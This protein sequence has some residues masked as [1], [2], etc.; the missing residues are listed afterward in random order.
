MD[1]SDPVGQAVPPQPPQGNYR[2]R[3]HYYKAFKQFCAFLSDNHHLQKLE[4]I[5]GKHLTSYVLWMQESSKSASTI[6]TDLAAVQFF[7][8]RMSQPKYQLLSNEEL[9]VE[10]ERR[11]FG[12]VNHTWSNVESSKMLGK[13]MAEDRYDSV[14]AFYLVRYAG[15]RIHECFRT[16]TALAEQVLRE[17]AVTIKGGK[18]RTIPINGKIAVAMREQSVHTP[19]GQKLLVPDGMPT[20]QAINHL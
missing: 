4:N 19:R 10:L 17:N 16:D 12:G 14:L 13:A 5:S 20:D 2:T 9:A 11:C 18:A 1:S 15:L 7:Y 3:E 8:D 6:K